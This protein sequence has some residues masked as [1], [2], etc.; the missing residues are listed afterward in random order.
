[1]EWNNKRRLPALALVMALA[2]TGCGKEAE[3]Q[4]EQQPT[5]TAVETQTVELSSIATQNTVSGKVVSDREASIMVGASVKCTAVYYEAGDEVQAGDVLCTLDLASTQAS[6]NAASIGYNS[7][8]E[9]YRNQSAVFAEQIALLQK[10]LEDLKALYEIGAAS[11]IEIDQASLQLQSAIATRDATLAQ[12]QASM[13]STKSSLK[14]LNTVLEDVDSQGNVIAPMSGTLVTMNAVEG[15]FV[16]AAM[17]VA[18]INDAS[19]MKVTVS[20]SETLVH[21]LSSG[22]QVEVSVSSVGKAFEGVIRSVEKAANAQTKLYTVTVA[23]PETMG[24]LLSGM[25]A[26]VT[27]FT[28]SVSDTV[29]IPT[30]AILTDGTVQYVFVAE[31]NTAKYVEITTG[32]TGD[33]VT[34]ITSGLTAGQQLVTVGQSYLSDGTPIRIVSDEMVQAILKEE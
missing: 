29:V 30:Q 3:V 16:S 27:F 20:V 15:N 4:Q 31:N 33:G 5:S 24:G 28:D 6:Y 26:D 14:Q 32:L 13:E 34:E 10:N 17:P 12:L 18:V 22:D 1:M 2:L 7:A 11:Q 21:K 19:A 8:A 23:V 25:F 9:S